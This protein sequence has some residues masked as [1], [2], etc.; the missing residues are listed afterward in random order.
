MRRSPLPSPA[1]AVATVLEAMGG[2]GLLLFDVT[3]PEIFFRPRPAGCGLR[4]N[5]R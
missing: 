3:M 2:A 1:G 5:P 4:P